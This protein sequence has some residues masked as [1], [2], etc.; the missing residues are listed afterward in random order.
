MVTIRPKTNITMRMEGVGET[1][2]RTVLSV[3]DLQSTIDEP[4]ERDGTNLGFSPTETLM[5]SLIGCTNVITQKIAHGM[6]VEVSGMD[7]KLRAQFNRL[8]VLLQQEVDRPFDDI[9]LDIDI[10]TNA[11]PEQMEAIK[12]DLAKFCPIAKVIRGN[13]ATITENWNVLPL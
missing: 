11:T 1:H 5:A 13:G 6:G 3:R 4:L 7:T 8:G 12:A 2:S 9:I 10:K